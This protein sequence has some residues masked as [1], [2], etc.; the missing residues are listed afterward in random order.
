MPWEYILH[1]NAVRLKR[2]KIVKFLGCLVGSV[3]GAWGFSFWDSDLEPLV[4]CR[5][6]L[7]R[8]KKKK[9]STNYLSEYGNVT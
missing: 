1:A 6:Y 5:D 9:S 4:E 3:G 2:H 7:S 8:L